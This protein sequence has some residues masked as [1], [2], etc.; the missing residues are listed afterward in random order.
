MKVEDTKL[1]GVL[2]LHPEVFHDKRGFF[3]EAWN[4]MRYEN[5]GIQSRFVQDNV[6]FSK[7]GTLRGLHFQYPQ[8]QGKLVQVLSGR[9]LD[10]VVDIRVASP[11]FGQ[12]VTVVL[13]GDNHRQLYVP[14]GFAHGYCVTSDTALFTYKCTDFYN[15]STECGIIWNDPDLN[16]DWPITQP[17]VSPKDATYPKLKDLPS[18]KLPHFGRL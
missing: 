18:E 3:L 16:I 14:P 8:P 4:S 2:V 12:W 13:G 11:T 9:V 5:A 10:V 17:L 6:S 7:K 15:P 1:P